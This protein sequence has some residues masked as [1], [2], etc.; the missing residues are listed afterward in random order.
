MNSKR[1]IFPGYGVVT[2]TDNPEFS[3]AVKGVYLEGD[4]LT[5]V[6]PSGSETTFDT[7]N[8]SEVRKTGRI[9]FESDGSEYLIRELS[10]DDGYWLSQYKTWLPL[11][12]IKS[13]INSQPESTENV[14]LNSPIESLVAYANDTSVYVLGL[15]YTNAAGVWARVG[16][17]WVLVPTENSPFENMIAIP[18]SKE[19]APEFIE[20][21]DK[22][23]VTVQDAEKYEETE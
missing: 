7:K 10:E 20:L 13:L 5:V 23:Y 22:N 6:S 2:Q 16:G 1:I 15:E 14:D 11:A 21:Y 18:I 9:S 17:D 3:L 8:I 4:T 12:A 19:Q